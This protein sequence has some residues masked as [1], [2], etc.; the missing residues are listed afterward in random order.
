MIL[1]FL[2]L[3]A[4][5]TMIIIFAYPSP[6]Q[7]KHTNQKD[8]LTSENQFFF[9]NMNNLH[10][11]LHVTLKLQNHTVELKDCHMASLL[12]LPFIPIRMLR[13]VKS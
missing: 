2:C 13:L 5:S 8:M 3:L 10:V 1:K 9:L 4:T 7:L 6:V 12:L 11:L